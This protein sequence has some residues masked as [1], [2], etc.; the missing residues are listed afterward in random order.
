MV[1][2]LD[3]KGKENIEDHGIMVLKSRAFTLGQVEVTLR[4]TGKMENGMDWVLN[5]EADGCTE[6]NG[7]KALKVD[8]VYDKLWCPMPNM[9]AP[10]PT[11]FKMVTALKRMQTEE[12]IKANGLEACDMATESVLVPL[13]AW[14]RTTNCQKPGWPPC[15]RSTRRWRP[16]TLRPQLL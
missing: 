3:P 14:P 9:R 4:V 16:L 6:A 15:H 13:L 2:A 11:A 7:R 10:G 8:M 1:S 5:P 12:R